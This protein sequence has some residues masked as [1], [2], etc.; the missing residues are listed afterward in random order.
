MTLG[1][2]KDI[3][4]HD[5][6]L[7]L[8]I[9]CILPNQTQGPPKE[10]IVPVILIFIHV[11]VSRY[12]NMPYHNDVAERMRLTICHLNILSQILS[13]LTLLEPDLWPRK[14]KSYK[15]FKYSKMTQVFSSK[16]SKGIQCHMCTNHPYPK[17][18]FLPLYQIR[19]QTHCIARAVQNSQ[20]R[21]PTGQQFDLYS[22]NR[23]AP[24]SWSRLRLCSPKPPYC[25]FLVACAYSRKTAFTKLK[26]Q[27]HLYYIYYS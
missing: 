7:T 27:E 14:R 11:C 18:T 12:G 24:F 16:E 8:L 3:W 2:R 10:P 9:I 17:L 1:L 26:M 21:E 5:S 25:R 19:L 23:K 22:V 4:C 6:H 15:C 20:Q 13:L